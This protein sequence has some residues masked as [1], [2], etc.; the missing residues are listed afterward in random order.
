MILIYF[1]GV[2]LISLFGIYFLYLVFLFF[3][4]KGYTKIGLTILFGIPLFIFLIFFVEE[5]TSKK[6]VINLLSENNIILV[7]EFIIE[8][9]STR[10]DI[11]FYELVVVLKISKKDM[12]L[13]INAIKNA[14]QFTSEQIAS[15]N[16]EQFGGDKLIQNYETDSFYVRESY[17]RGGYHRPF[18]KRISVSKFKSQL[19]FHELNY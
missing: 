9:D 13:I 6:E 11:D 10:N 12:N 18:W 15:H 2:V 4:A 19:E 14:E 7:D 16:R 3:K 5:H 1:I 8:S 17:E